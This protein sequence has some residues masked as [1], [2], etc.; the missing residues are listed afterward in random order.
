VFALCPKA[1]NNPYFNE[2]LRGAKDAAKQLNLPEPQWVG[3]TEADAGQQV[4]RINDL[5]TRGV[6]GIGISPNSP[7][8]V[9]N[10]ISRAIEKKIP[11]ITFDADAPKSK[12]AAYIGT[13]NLEAGRKAGQEMARILNGKGN[14][15]VVSGGMGAFN[16]NQRVEGFRKGL[17]GSGVKV[18]SVQYCDDDQLKAHRIIQDYLL[19]HPDTQGIFAAGLWA[20][21]PA[22][23][24]LKQKKRVGK[25]KVVGFDTL[26]EELQLVKDGSVQVLVGQRPYEMGKRSIEVLNALHQGKQPQA[27][28]ID[29][30]TDVVTS[31][32]VDQFLSGGT[33]SG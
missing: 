7:E 3:G 21:L 4:Q 18:A 22:G 15:L 33:K 5:I 2:V 25:I 12:R 26:Q 1:I 6:Q 29:T 8:T 24:I 30:G 31:A 13:D 19:S 17:E 23:Q 16:L 11:V 20:V 32:N 14:V 9:A 27:Q 10:P 28:V